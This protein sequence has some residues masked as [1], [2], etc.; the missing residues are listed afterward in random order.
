MHCTQLRS[1]VWC[2]LQESVLVVPAFSAHYTH[3]CH[4]CCHYISLLSPL[5]AKV[6]LQV[7]TGIKQR[8][9][10]APLATAAAALS[11][12]A[13][14]ALEAAAAASSQL[15]TARSELLAVLTAA[16]LPCARRLAYALAVATAAL[17]A[18]QH[19][20]AAAEDSAARAALAAAEAAEQQQ[21]LAA[22]AQSDAPLQDNDSPEELDEEAQQ[23][24]ALLSKRS[25]RRGELRRLQ[26]DL[27]AQ[28]MTA[29][30]VQAK[31]E[32]VLLLLL[33]LLQLLLLLLLSMEYVRDYCLLL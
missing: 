29:V 11:P 15:D 6:K 12:A 19:R 24:K 30:R 27:R 25:E 31:R 7:L 3:C 9:A 22:A 21:L 5:Q 33:L 10:A 18:A 20:E 26:L 17:D 32:Q 28:R 14:A 4:C 13:V 23:V 1:Q 2:I 16:R 8:A